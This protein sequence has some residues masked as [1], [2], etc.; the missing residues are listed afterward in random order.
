VTTTSILNV[1]FSPSTSEGATLEGLVFLQ[2][3]KNNCFYRFYQYHNNSEGSGFFSRGE[4]FHSVD[5]VTTDIALSHTSMELSESM[6]L[7]LIITTNFDS[8]FQRDLFS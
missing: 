8:G 7:P 2:H 4:F 1:L 3:D 6:E 5:A